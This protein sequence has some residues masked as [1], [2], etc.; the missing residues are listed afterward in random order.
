MRSEVLIKNRPTLFARYGVGILLLILAAACAPLVYDFDSSEKA[1][2]YQS[3]KIELPPDSAANTLTIMT[4][5]I[6]FGA[7]RLPWFGD[8]CGNRVILTETEVKTNLN[9][10]AEK[11][12]E[13]Q[14][15][16]LFLQEVDV[17]SKRTA[18]LDEMQ[19]LLDHT[20]LNYGAFASM[21]HVQFIPSDGLGRMNMGTAILS[22][23]PLKNMERIALPLRSDQDALTQYFYLR[24]CIVKA[25]VVLP[26]VDKLYAVGVHTA[27]F[28][29]DNTKQKHIER[30]LQE[31]NNLDDAGIPFVAGGDLNTL[32]PGSD[33][34]DFCMEDA[35]SGESFHH[36]GDKP[37]HKEGSDY[38][39][40]I[41]WLD[42]LYT[43]YHSAVPRWEY[44]Y[45]QSAYFTHTTNHPN[46]FWNRKLDYLFSNH[47]FISDSDKTHQEATHCS[48]HAPVSVKWRVPK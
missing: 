48:D 35:C 46:G 47:F 21:W 43:H 30:F 1:V 34:T 19:W 12:N 16:I 9:C 28:S 15:D 24:R 42:D 45:H 13:I 6:R 2:S 31:L 18:Y 38:T 11:I 26:G 25:Q 3:Q 44:P 37:F 39:K 4:W 14:P 10:I 27:A 8:A 20:E 23:W 29:T 32:P 36:A 33:S 7:G 40:E 5:N 41:G 22:R 17:Q